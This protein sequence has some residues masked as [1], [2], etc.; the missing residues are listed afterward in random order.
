MQ[1]LPTQEKNLVK[2]LSLRLKSR[3]LHFLFA[4][5]RLSKLRSQKAWCVMKSNPSHAKATILTRKYFRY[6]FK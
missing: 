4:H 6:G 3:I 5:L 1:S 2:V